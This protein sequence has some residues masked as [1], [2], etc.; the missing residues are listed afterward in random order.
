MNDLKKI[1][2][3]IRKKVLLMHTNAKVSH[4]GSS[5][6]CIE[7][8]AALYFHVLKIF[9]EQ[10]DH[11]MRD[12]FILSKGHASSALYTTL[13]FRELIPMIWIE[14]DFYQGKLPG[15]PD[16]LLTPF[17]EVSTGSLGHGL[18]IGVG[19]AYALKLDNR[20]ART[21]VLMSDGEIQEG[22]V[23]EAA[24]NASRLKLDNLIGIIDANRLQGF[25]KTDNIMPIA[26]FRAKWEAFGWSVEEI[27]GHDLD[28][29]IMVLKDIPFKT[30]KPSLLIAHTI[31]GKGIEEFEDKLEWHYHSPKLDNLEE[32]LKELDEESSS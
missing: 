13:A 26:S 4:I 27:D 12:R 30:E 22:S 11:P 1:A 9:P 16:R 23:W 28:A 29:L 18:P 8:L 19:R 15:H 7:I 31:K 14:K 20:Q 3:E 5:F 24:N 17:I 25:E 21:F 10:P 6:S 32:Y 2:K